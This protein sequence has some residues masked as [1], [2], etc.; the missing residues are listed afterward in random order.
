M[1][2]KDMANTG[3]AACFTGKSNPTMRCWEVVQDRGQLVST[4]AWM[5]RMEWV[6]LFVTGSRGICGTMRTKNG[7]IREAMKQAGRRVWG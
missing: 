2:F 5:S 6:L 7:K 3:R 1:A 4:S